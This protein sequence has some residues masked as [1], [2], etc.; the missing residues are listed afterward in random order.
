MDKPEESF[1]FSDRFPE[2]F[3]LVKAAFLVHGGDFFGKW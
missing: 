2:V 3:R 1:R